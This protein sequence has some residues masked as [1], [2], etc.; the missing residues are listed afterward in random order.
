MPSGQERERPRIAPSCLRRFEKSVCT[1]APK[2]SASP[3]GIAGAAR[4]RRASIALVTSGGGQKHPGGSTA[5]CSTS[6]KA[7]TM[8]VSGPYSPLFGC[9]R[10]RSPTSRWM[11]TNCP[12]HCGMVAQIAITGLAA[13]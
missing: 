6:Q 4:G 1:N 2:A 12:R 10:S 5:T 11:V 8:S 3:C 9:A 7:C 13:W